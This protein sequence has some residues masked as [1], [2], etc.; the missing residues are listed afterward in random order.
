MMDNLDN[1]SAAIGR[2]A[3]AMAWVGL[4][5]GQLHALSRHAT[6]VGSSD[7]ELPTTAFWAEP[8]ADL[9]SP[10]LDWGDPD[11]VYVTYGKLWLPVFASFFLC[12]LLTYRRREPRGFERGVWRVLLVCYGAAVVSV[13]GEYW[14]QWTGE[15][16]I[17][18]G[19]VF[20]VS[21]PVILGVLVGSTLLGVCLLRSGFRPRTAA[22]LLTATL[23]A[24]FVITEFTSMGSI[25]LP[26]AFAFGII[27]RRMARESE[28]PETRTAASPVRG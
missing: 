11:L 16:N 22:W 5:G 12:A 26:I 7:L 23:P 9:L 20:L 21:I 24:A 13:V 17:L 14:T 25:V 10:L 27:G 2:F 3:W 8:A 18:L 1:H 15:T 4:V 28:R 19:L 6:A